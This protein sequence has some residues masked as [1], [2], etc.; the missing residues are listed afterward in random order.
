MFLRPQ[1]WES[2]FSVHLHEPF[3]E[4]CSG[5]DFFYP[6]Y[7]RTEL[8]S[9]YKVKI[10]DGKNSPQNPNNRLLVEALL[11]VFLAFTSP[12]NC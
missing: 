2:I 6:L 3:L 11:N 10:L 4:C 1:L 9:V 5:V 7:L 12:E 8:K